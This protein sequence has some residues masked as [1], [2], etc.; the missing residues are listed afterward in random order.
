MFLRV[1]IQLQCLNM[2]SN[3][4]HMYIYIYTHA[5][6]ISQKT[7]KTIAIGIGES[8][9]LGIEK[10]AGGA[11]MRERTLGEMWNL[12]W[13]QIYIYIYRICI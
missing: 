13:R 3:M 4:L 7:H 11:A 8:S 2:F 1:F 5:L 12:A 9:A 6:P 10:K